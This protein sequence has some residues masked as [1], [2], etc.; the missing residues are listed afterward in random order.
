[1][2]R[3]QIYP[4]AG[5]VNTWPAN[6]GDIYANRWVEF[7]VST[8]PS[9][10]LTVDTISMYAGSGGGVNL[11]YRVEYSTQPDFSGGVELTALS[12]PSTASLPAGV[13][14]TKNDM[15][16][17][18]TTGQS[19]VVPPGSTLHIRILPW[20]QATATASGKYLLLQSFTVHGW[21]Q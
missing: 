15:Y 13:T 8:S 19:I 11:F 16:F 17:R 14:Y 12:L 4:D 6:E 1:M 20:N 5:G 21:V 7:A 9:K 10:T 3:S 18:R 2:Q